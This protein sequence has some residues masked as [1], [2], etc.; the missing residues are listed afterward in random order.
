[1]R[2]PGIIEGGTANQ[3]K[4]HA[5]ADYVDATHEP[6]VT[7]LSLGDANGHEVSDLA[8]AIRRQKACHQHVS[9]RPIELLVAEATHRGGNLETPALGVIE[10]CREDA[11]GIEAWKTQPV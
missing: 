10:E 6:L 2:I 3:S 8:H 11:G 1:M 5:A 9:I 7:G 4:G